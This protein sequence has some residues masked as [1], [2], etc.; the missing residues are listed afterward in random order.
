MLKGHDLS[1]AAPCRRIDAGFS[2]CGTYFRFFPLGS[3]QSA[4]YTLEP[5]FNRRN[6]GRNASKTRSTADPADLQVRRPERPH[7]ITCQVPFP[8]VLS[9]PFSLQPLTPNGEFAGIFSPFAILD[10]S[11]PKRRPPPSGFAGM[12]T[13][14]AP[15]EACRSQNRMLS[16]CHGFSDCAAT[17]PGISGIVRHKFRQIGYLPRASSPKPLKTRNLTKT[18]PG[19]EWGGPAVQ[20]F[21]TKLVAHGPLQ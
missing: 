13:P 15:S 20:T 17:K 9:Q 2:P 1:R 11:I 18:T 8:G 14:A 12:T 3:R 4:H 5:L 10:L 19:G 16:Q 6:L 21:R 7:S